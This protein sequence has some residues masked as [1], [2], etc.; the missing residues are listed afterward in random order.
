MYE[1]RRARGRRSD[2]RCRLGPGVCA[3]MAGGVESAGQRSAEAGWAAIILECRVD[4]C[5]VGLEERKKTGGRGIGQR[6]EA[7]Q[8]LK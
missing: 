4:S 3:R 7:D 8:A 5:Q 6:E 2:L 1:R